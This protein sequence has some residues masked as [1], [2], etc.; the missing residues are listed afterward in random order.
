VA[1]IHIKVS[2]LV[3]CHRPRIE[4]FTLAKQAGLVSERPASI[5][6]SN[7]TVVDRFKVRDLWHQTTFHCTLCSAVA[8]ARA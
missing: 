7:L 4:A 1:N 6:V 5:M 8:P 3:T 2:S